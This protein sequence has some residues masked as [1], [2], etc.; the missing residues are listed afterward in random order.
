MDPAQRMTADGELS[1]IVAQQRADD[2]DRMQSDIAEYCSVGWRREPDS[3]RRGGC[4]F[5]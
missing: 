1:G 3:N 5:D 4:L 2:N